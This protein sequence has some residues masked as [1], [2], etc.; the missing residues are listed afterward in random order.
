[1]LKVTFDKMLLFAVQKYRSIETT[2]MEYVR[3]C[4]C[5]FECAIIHFPHNLNYEREPY[6]TCVYIPAN[7]QNNN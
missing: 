1:M 2:F 3:V 7:D 6:V 4:V 5:L